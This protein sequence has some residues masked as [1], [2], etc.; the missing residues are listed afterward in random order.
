MAPG[1]VQPP[2]ELRAPNFAVESA[3]STHKWMT[4]VIAIVG[5]LAVGATAYKFQSL[6]LPGI[7]G[8]AKPSRAAAARPAVLAPEGLSSTLGLVTYDREGQLQI[9][10]DR[11]SNAIRNAAN[12]VLEI[13]EEGVVPKAIQLD[14]GNLQTGSFSYARTA[15]KV[16]VKLLIHQKAGPDLRE[17]T[18]FLGKVPD[19]DRKAKEEAEALKRR[20]AEAVRQRDAMAEQAAKMKADLSSQAEKTK[21]LEKD[22]DAMRREMRRQQQRR[23]ANQATDK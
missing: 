13:S 5:G 20:E 14:A 9:Y 16:D 8:S 12:G 18:S 10:W 6:W 21:K 4:I 11:G 2:A 22:M 1:D 7:M 17:S 19:V 3:S 23:M 15:A